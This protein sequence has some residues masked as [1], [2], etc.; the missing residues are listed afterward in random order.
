MTKEE[1]EGII[2]EIKNTNTFLSDFIDKIKICL[3]DKE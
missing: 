1:T 2:N 3:D